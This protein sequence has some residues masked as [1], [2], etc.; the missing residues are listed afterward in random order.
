MPCTLRRNPI[1]R[2]RGGLLHSFVTLKDLPDATFPGILR[3]FVGL[4][5]PVTVN[6]EVTIPDQA[7]VI[8]HYKSKMQAVQRDSHGNVRIDVDAQVAQRQLMET[9]KQLISSSLKTC[10]TSMVIG[11]RA[12]TAGPES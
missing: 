11:V 6:T 8:T 2:K 1:L 3:D 10:R 4:N 7:A 5:F 12:S 9:P